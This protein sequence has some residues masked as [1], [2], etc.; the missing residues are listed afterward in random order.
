LDMVIVTT[1]DPDAPE[2]LQFYV[3]RMVI[4]ENIIDAVVNE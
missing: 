3:P 1:A 4:E 2:G